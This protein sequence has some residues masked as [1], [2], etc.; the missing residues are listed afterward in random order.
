MTD[1]ELRAW[2]EA[3]ATGKYRSPVAV[4]VLVMLADNSRLR[5]TLQ[6]AAAR[7]ADQSEILSRRAERAF[8]GEPNPYRGQREESSLSGTHC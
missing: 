7:I 1:A 5:Q 6:S 4:A 3:H 8:A 2:A